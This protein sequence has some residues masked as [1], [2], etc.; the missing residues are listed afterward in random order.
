MDGVLRSGGGWADTAGYTST[1]Q[2]ATLKLYDGNTLIG[3]TGGAGFKINSKLFVGGN[4]TPTALLHLAAGTTA[5]AQI[6]MTS[7]V[8]PTSP[9]DGDMWYDGADVKFRVGGITKTFTLT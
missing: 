4:T 8:A 1:L 9:N 5:A 6:C 3:I 7:G 2:Y